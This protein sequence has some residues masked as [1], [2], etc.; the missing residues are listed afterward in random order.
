MFVDECHATGF[1]GNTGRLVWISVGNCRSPLLAIAWW[2]HGDH[3]S[4]YPWLLQLSR[5][6]EEF[7]GY[8]GRVDIIN[9]TLGKALGGAA[10]GYTTG[11]RELVS[12]LRQKSR[13]YLFSNTLPPPVVAAATK[14][15]T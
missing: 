15:R 1:F 13:P 10:G 14:V 7:C 2:D 12:L 3:P 9:S 5:G 11:S 4:T 6:T 8:K